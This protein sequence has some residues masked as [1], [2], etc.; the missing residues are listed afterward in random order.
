MYLI[1][2]LG[3]FKK[4]ARYIIVH[5]LKARLRRTDKVFKMGLEIINLVQQY[6]YLSIL[7]DEHLKFD[8]CDN[9]FAKSGGRALASLIS[10]YNIN[11]NFNHDIYTYLFNACIF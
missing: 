8:S 1:F 6:K 3:H 11:K 2:I 9:V 10:K 5:F 4:E 7:L